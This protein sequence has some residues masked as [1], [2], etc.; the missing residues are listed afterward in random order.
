MKKNG[1]PHNSELVCLLCDS[2]VH[3]RYL[4]N[5]HYHRQYRSERPKPPKKEVKSTPSLP[6]IKCLV[7]A[8]TV[9]VVDGVELCT[10]HGN[11]A[12]NWG[13]TTQRLVAILEGN[14]CEIC[15]S[16]DKL[17]LDHVHDLPCDVRHR[18]LNGCEECYRGLLC[19]GCNRAIGFVQEDV[20]RLQGAIRYLSNPR[21]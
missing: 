19:N 20:T 16:A 12:R 11:R 13:L 3:S 8:C 18:G 2:P 21:K 5:R 15:G 10:A 6:G 17:V 1:K 7:T 4:C 9:R 14:A